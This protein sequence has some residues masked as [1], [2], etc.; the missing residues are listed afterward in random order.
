MASGST[1]RA[2]MTSSGEF[3]VEPRRRLYDDDNWQMYDEEGNILVTETAE[4]F[5]AAARPDVDPDLQN[6]CVEGP[7]R[8]AR[9]RRADH[10]HG[11]D[12][13]HARRRRQRAASQG[14]QG[15]TL[16]GVVIAASAPVDA[17]LG[18]LHDR[19]VRRLRRPLQPVRGLPHARGGRLL[20]GRRRRRRRHADVR[21]RDGRLRGPQ[22]V[23][24]HAEDA[25]PTSTSATATPPTPTAT[26]TT[27]TAR[28]RTRSSS[29]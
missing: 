7:A 23:R 21:L 3:F 16:D 13:D 28:R 17:I 6:H 19:G 14:N 15:V 9:E 29:A 10:D 27:P 26:T 12:P 24:R 8:M 22:P 4:E 11:A 20:G 2:S 5:E 25:A 1:A 18:R